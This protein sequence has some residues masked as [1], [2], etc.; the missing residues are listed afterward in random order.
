DLHFFVLGFDAAHLGVLRQIA[1]PSFVQGGR[2]LLLLPTERR[3]GRADELATAFVFQIE[4][5]RLDVHFHRRLIE[6]PEVL[7]LL[8]GERGGVGGAG[9][10]RA[11]GGLRGGTAG[12]GG[13]AG[14]S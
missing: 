6:E 2:Q 3:H 5:R 12:E 10:R 7:L 8:L 13:G 4:V 14:A 1:C 11:G 9:A